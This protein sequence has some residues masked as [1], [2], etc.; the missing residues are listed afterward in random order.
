MHLFGYHSSI[1]NNQDMEVTSVLIS[2]WM[3]KEEV[4][5]IH[6]GVLLSHKNRWNLNIWKLDIMLSEISQQWQ[7]PYDST[8]TWNIQQNKVSA[9]TKSNN[10]KHTGTGKRVVV[11]D[12]IGLGV[13]W[14]E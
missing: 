3:D 6:N 10:N 14:N 13:G 2:E 7:I 8:Y 4:A 9:Q 11:P 1:Y 5:Y 12:E